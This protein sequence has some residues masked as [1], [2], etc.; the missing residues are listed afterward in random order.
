MTT[1]KSEP[2]APALVKR[3]ET[4]GYVR[5]KPIDA[6]RLAKLAEAAG[7][8]PEGLT[9][10][11]LTSDGLD[12]AELLS[13]CGSEE[14]LAPHPSQ[15]L[16]PLCDDGN[17]NYDAVVV[18]PGLLFGAVIFWDHETGK[19]DHLIASSVVAYL[20]LLGKWTP[21]FIRS[22]NDQTH[23]DFLRAHDGGAARL[24]DDPD[25]A[26]WVGDSGRTF[27]LEPEPYVPGEPLPKGAREGV[28]PFTNE[29]Q[30]FMPLPKHRTPPK[31]V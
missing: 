22:A 1:T 27:R 23:D 30:I 6:K 28:N 14:M 19:A 15:S 17:G 9:R 25:F 10:Y 16:L 5:R 2:L 18:E 8:L 29:R 7:S 4:L 24:L 26:T 12:S 13:I 31:R 11:L 20:E 21:P 3:L